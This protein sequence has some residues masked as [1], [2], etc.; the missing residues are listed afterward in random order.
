MDR[1]ERPRVGERR[2]ENVPIEALGIVQVAD[3]DKA[4][5]LGPTEHR[6]HPLS[7]IGRS[8]AR[9]RCNTV[10]SP[11]SRALLVAD[12]KSHISP[13]VGHH[14]AKGPSTAVIA[15]SSVSAV[16]RRHLWVRVLVWIYD[17]C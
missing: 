9:C 6:Q 16:G 10:A 5:L 3:P 14:G 8:T 17:I 11:G 15:T 13:E 7:P 4:D 2:A 1:G 12:I